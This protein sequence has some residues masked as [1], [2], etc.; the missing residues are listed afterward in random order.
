M[1][2]AS[3]FLKTKDVSLL[4]PLRILYR[5]KG[6][7]FSNDERI[8]SPPRINL[9]KSSPPPPLFLLCSV[10]TMTAVM[11]MAVQVAS[12]ARL[13]RCARHPQHLHHPLRKGG[14]DNWLFRAV[15]GTPA[16]PPPTSGRDNNWLAQSQQFTSNTRGMPCSPQKRSACFLRRDRDRLTGADATTA[17]VWQ[18][19]QASRRM[20]KYSSPSDGCLRGR[21]CQG[22]RTLNATDSTGWVY[23]VRRDVQ[24]CACQNQNR[25]IPSPR[26]VGA[27]GLG[28]SRAGHTFSLLA[29]PT[30]DL[31]RSE[32][33]Q[34][35]YRSTGAGGH[36]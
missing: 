36:I 21:S 24:Y 13:P 5:L 16:S 31:S 19:T 6:G 12:F 34:E 17:G 25:V 23:C 14:N 10:T 20:L 3:N 18:C 30:A 22:G 11:P 9:R 26:R 35:R 1:N 28:C 8:A 4:T 33:T 29:H 2:L 27:S 32:V 7:S 15:L